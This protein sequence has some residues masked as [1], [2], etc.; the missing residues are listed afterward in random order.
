M[1][2]HYIAMA[3]MSA[4]LLFEAARSFARLQKRNRKNHININR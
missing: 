2:V 1:T 3:C 4:F